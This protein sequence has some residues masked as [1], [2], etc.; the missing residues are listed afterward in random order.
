MSRAPLLLVLLPA[1]FGQTVTGTLE[2]HVR[3]LSGAVVPAAQIEAIN[4]ENGLKRATVTNQDGFYQLTFLPVGEYRVTADRSGFAKVSRAALVELNSARAIDFDLK[5]STVA[6]EVT[7]AA[8][9]PLIDVTRGDVKSTIDARMIEDRPLSSRNFLSLVEMFAGFQT[10]SSYSGVNNPTLSSGSYVSFNGTG[11]RSAAFQIDGVNND[12][13]SEGSNRQN[14]NV[15]SI[16]E[17]QV[18]TNAYSAEFGRAGGA[19]VLVQTKSGTNRFHGDVYEYFQNEKLN[20]NAYFNNSFGLKTDGTPVAPRAPYR[21][22][23]FG[24]TVGGPL[25][26]NKLFLFNTFEQTRLIQYNTF[27]RF[28]FRPTDKLQVGDCRLCLKPEEHPNLQADMA[29]LQGILD[30]F[31]KTAPN[32]PAACANCYTETKPASY[33]DQDYSGKLDWSATSRDTFALRYHYSRQKRKP[34]AV[35]D[36]ESAYQNNR[37]QNVGLTATHMFS[38]TTWGEFRFGLGLRT[39]LVDI[40]TGNNTPVVRINNPTAYT[41]TTLGSAG[42]FPINR[43]QSDYQFVYNIS[44]VRGRHV[45]R[46]GIDYRRQH[47]DD[48]ADNYSRGWWTFAATGTVGAANR[49]E[50]WENFLRGYISSFQKGYGNFTTYNRLGDYNQYV[51]D[52]FKVKP[53]FTLN[54]GYRWEVV[55]KPTERDGRTEYGYGTFWRGLEPRFGFAWAPKPGPGFW[56]KITGDPGR[57]AVRGGYGIFHNRVFQ[58]VFSQGGASLRSQPPYGVFRAF[59]PGFEV[60]DPSLGFVY[61]PNYNPGRIG[62]ARTDPGLRMPNVQQLHF[63]LERQLPGQISVSIGYNRNRAI[64]LMQNQSLNRARFPIVSPN[65]GVLYDKIDPDPGNTAPA[66]GFISLAQP[67]TNLRRPDPRYSTI[68][69]FHN[70]GWSYYNALR[71]ELRKRL[72]RGLHFLVNYSFSKTIDTGSDVTAGV[73]VTEFGSAKSLRGLSDFH[74]AHRTNIN[75]AY[76]LPWLKRARGA[77]GLLGGW[78]VSSNMTMAT[79]NPFNVTTGYDYNADG[80]ANDRPLLLDAS[81]FGR[82]V[83]NARRDANGRQFSVQQLPLSGFFP[84]VFTPATQRPFDPGGSGGGSLGRN[85]FFAQGLFNIDFG[86]YKHFAV[87]EGHRLTFRAELYGATNTPHFAFPTRTTSSQAFGAISSSYNPFNYVG[88]SR[89]DASARVIQLALR[90]VF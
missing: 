56:R 49:Y 14:V 53:N 1:A 86:L 43:F 78:T 13:S 51:M 79:A 59:D 4:T 10:S 40:S 84:T 25:V 76:E 83:D 80:V 34:F 7:V 38:P 73:T 64:G 30:R 27:T 90:Y 47:L 9:I 81:L 31:P 41:T 21:R 15:S 29:F 33:P 55:L 2:G 6:T 5:P 3:D 45:I 54:L 85:T 62:I 60:A 19:V 74:Q 65:D 88:A 44:H 66:P 63:T 24:Y 50:G 69:V 26:R 37:Q 36:G 67:R 28:I 11:S 8:E 35:I 48:L 72:S 87:R 17:F 32:N 89:S 58:S 12:D 75:A 46:T 57:S 71:L 82:S 20:A 61:S 23:Q 39:T 70:S 42:Q 77:R 16:R 22:N 52:D 68:T 18:L